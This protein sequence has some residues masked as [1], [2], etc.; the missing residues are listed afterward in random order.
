M[1]YTVAVTATAVV[2]P[3]ICNSGRIAGF[4]QS[5]LFRGTACTEKTM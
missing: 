3:E 4:G 1:K 5:D 2:E